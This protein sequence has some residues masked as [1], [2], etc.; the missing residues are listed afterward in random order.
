MIKNKR[1]LIY[2]TILI[3]FTLLGCT[4]HKNDSIEQS[5]VIEIP[6]LNLSVNT[7]TMD[8]LLERLVIKNNNDSLRVPTMINKIDDTYYIVDCSNHNILYCNDINAELTQWNKLPGSFNKPHCFVGDG[9]FFIV[10]DTENNR[11]A[12]YKKE[13]DSFI[14]IESIDNIGFRP[15]YAMYHDEHY[16]VWNGVNQIYVYTENNYKLILENAYYIPEL[17]GDYV[18]SFTLYDDEWYFPTSSGKIVVTDL[19][20]TY[21]REYSVP[22]N[23]AG[24]SY[25]YKRDDYW[26]VNVFT[27]IE[28]DT[29][30][31]DLVRC[32]DL[33]LL[34]TGEYESLYD[35]LGLKSSPYY[36]YIF[37]DSYYMTTLSGYNAIYRLDN[38][39]GE[40]SCVQI[41]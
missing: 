7:D 12:T 15:H 27:N 26:Y 33:S 34:E 18:R 25:I 31:T 41:F 22:N 1:L 38:I 37:D 4:N 39:N 35:K 24:L 16:Y 36:V 11:L 19:N 40:I 28:Y 32:K 23:I 6:E 21:T 5:E 17:E 8:K 10:V 2:S 13:N 30:Y 14:F 9:T 29:S 20:F 3:L